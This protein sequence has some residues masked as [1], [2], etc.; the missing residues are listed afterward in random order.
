M[1]KEREKLNENVIAINDWCKKFVEEN[2]Y[3][4]DEPIHFYPDYELTDNYGKHYS[5]LIDK[6]GIAVHNGSSW[7]Y[8]DE[9]ESKGT[10]RG[11]LLSSFSDCKRLVLQWKQVKQSIYDTWNRILKDIETIMEFEV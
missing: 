4:I 1:T 5:V 6:H 10:Y 11:Y 8:A 7:L 3:K 9:E 2:Q